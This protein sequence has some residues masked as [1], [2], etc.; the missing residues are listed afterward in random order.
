MSD[1][2]HPAHD[3]PKDNHTPFAYAITSAVAEYLDAVVGTPDKGR[4][5]TASAHA[6]AA[7]KA[8]KTREERSI[9]VRLGIALRVLVEGITLERK[10]P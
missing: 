9:A 5:L 3:V 10:K 8:A 6:E 4:L 1:E 7:V 2:E